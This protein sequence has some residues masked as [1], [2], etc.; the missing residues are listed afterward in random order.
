MIEEFNNTMLEKCDNTDIVSF[1]ISENIIINKNYIYNQYLNTVILNK[2][3]NLLH[4]RYYTDS[5]TLTHNSGLDSNKYNNDDYKWLSNDSF[6][7]DGLDDIIDISKITIYKPYNKY[8]FFSTNNSTIYGNKFVFEYYKTIHEVNNVKMNYYNTSPSDIY[9]ELPQVIKNNINMK[10]PIRKH[11][12]YNSI[13]GC[14]ID[15]LP[16]IIKKNI[17]IEHHDLEKYYKRYIMLHMNNK[18]MTHIKQKYNLSYK[19]IL[20]VKYQLEGN[21][22]DNFTLAIVC[23][24]IFKM[25]IKIFRY[26]DNDNIDYF[27]INEG[28]LVSIYIYNIDKLY[29]LIISKYFLLER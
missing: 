21:I 22:E 16:K 10:H 8:P 12:K 29:E 5:N 17:D 23:S 3:D 28:G 15:G 11:N 4:V 6:I 20:L 1:N 24:E 7:M 2:H 19:N 14:I 13:I 9:N 25:N 27:D 26:I 18:Y